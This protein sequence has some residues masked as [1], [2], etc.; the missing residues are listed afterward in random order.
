M[1]K[2]LADLDKLVNFHYNHQALKS[3]VAQL[4]LQLKLTEAILLLYKT[5]RN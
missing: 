2:V 1:P 3:E 4:K 5:K